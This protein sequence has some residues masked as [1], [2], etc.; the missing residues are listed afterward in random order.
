VTPSIEPPVTANAGA[1][2]AR[3]ATPTS[4]SLE[5]DCGDERRERDHEQHH[6]NE[7]DVL[8]HVDGPLS[9]S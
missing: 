2:T 1:A 6:G 4:A 7:V 9:R 5:L 3:A 8:L